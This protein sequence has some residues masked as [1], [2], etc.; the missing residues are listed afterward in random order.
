MK[1]KMLIIKILI[2]FGIM[3]II[4]FIMLKIYAVAFSG[5]FGFLGSMS[6]ISGLFLM[7]VPKDLLISKKMKFFSM[8]FNFG[9]GIMIISFFAIMMLIL[10]SSARTEMVKADYLVILGAGVRGET[11]SLTLM[12]RLDKSIEYIN[13]YPEVKI[14][15]SGGKGPGENISEAEAMKRYLVEHKVD[16]KQIIKEDRSTSTNENIKF[17]KQVIE[18]IDKK[19]NV[20]IAL[21][22]SDFHMF[23][24]KAIAERNGFEVHSIP[25]KVLMWIEP[26]CY[27]REYFAVI[28]FLMN[29]F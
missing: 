6:I 25:A 18:N 8:A 22:T 3:S 28:K 26:C 9:F 17:T 27:V 1:H 14:I 5:F 12:Q 19:E 2:G 24:S 13:K 4:Y 7:Y 16:E 15:V 23:R 11:P 29:I 20:K 10:N 21:V